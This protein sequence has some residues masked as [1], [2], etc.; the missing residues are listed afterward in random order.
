MADSSY[1]QPPTATN[2]SGTGGDPPPEVMNMGF[3]WGAFFLHWIWG[4]A[5]GV[6]NSFLVIILGIIWQIVLGVKGNEWAWRNRKF[7]S[8][9][10]FKQTQAVWSKWGIIV[11][12]VV[13]VLCAV[14]MLP[15]VL[16]IIGAGIAAGVDAAH[17]EGLR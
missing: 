1:Q 6:W 15:A 14:V 3:N 13:F 9:E 2:N 8:V 10:Q 12:V 16:R 7:E 11:F 4:V 5:H 17:S